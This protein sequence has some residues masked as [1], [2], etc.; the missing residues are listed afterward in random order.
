MFCLGHLGA[1]GSTRTFSLPFPSL[2]KTPLV[3]I[4]ASFSHPMN[5]SLWHGNTLFP[6]QPCLLDLPYHWWFVD[7]KNPPRPLHSFS[8]VG[9]SSICRD[10][11]LLFVR[12]L[13]PQPL[14]R[15]QPKKEL[16]QEVK[17]DQTSEECAKHNIGASIFLNKGPKNYFPQQPLKVTSVSNTSM[18]GN[19]RILLLFY[20][21]F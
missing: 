17:L 11:C 18:T 15:I 19:M 9:L 2:S 16:S 14:E 3:F 6:S 5:V 21:S 13:W 20:F 1:A 4:F 7:T 8:N 10:G 12:P